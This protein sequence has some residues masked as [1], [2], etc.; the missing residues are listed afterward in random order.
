MRPPLIWRAC[1]PDQAG[2][3]QLAVRAFRELQAAGLV[4]NVVTRAALISGLSRARRRG[5]PC[6]QQAYELWKELEAS[7]DAA[8]NACAYAA[9]ASLEV[10]SHPRQAPEP[11]VYFRSRQ[12]RHA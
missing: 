8:S 7:G 1:V 6:A 5:A 3:A 4:P 11:L 2:E 9:G 10:F 12:R